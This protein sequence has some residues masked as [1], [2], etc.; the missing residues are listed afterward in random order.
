MND[1][2]GKFDITYR[3][4]KDRVILLDTTVYDYSA[5]EVVKQL[6]LLEAEDKKKD[7]KMF[8]NSPGGVVTDGLMIIDTMNLI[9]PDVST[10]IMGQAASMEAVIASCGTRG[11][12]F[13]TKNSRIMIHQVSGGTWG[14]ESD[15]AI[16]AAEA[17]RLK[18]QL[19]TILSKNTGKT[20]KKVEQDTE[21]DYYMSAQ[22]A[23]EYGL[24]DKII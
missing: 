8:I 24:I 21:R 9:S 10:I 1:G 20:V 5:S 15:I 17:A 22:E 6:M 12:R 13:A 11:K 19:N 23:L 14:T 4:L 7:I 3:L 18:K 16:Q 2:Y